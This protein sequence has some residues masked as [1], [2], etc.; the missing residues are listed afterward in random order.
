MMTR[1]TGNRT[2]SE[3]FSANNGVKQGCVLAH[4]F[5]GLMSSAMVIDA[6]LDG[7]PENRLACGT[8][9][10]LLHGLRM[11]ASTRLS[12]TSIHDLLFTDDYALNTVADADMQRSMNLF[13]SSCVNFGQNDFMHQLH[14]MLHTGLLASTS[15]APN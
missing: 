3:A 9:I 5:F 4:T 12:T 8:D 14:P 6:Y 13:T 11:Q 2:A 1:G 7:R 15:T 10:Q